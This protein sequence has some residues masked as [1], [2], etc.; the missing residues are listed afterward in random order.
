MAHTPG[1]YEAQLLSF[2]RELVREALKVL[3]ASDH[4]AQAQR[5]RDELASVDPA[6]TEREP[7]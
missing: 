5:V 6:S 3:R 7:G 2:S 1:A 4:I